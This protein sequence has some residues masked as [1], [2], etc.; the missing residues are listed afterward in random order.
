MEQKI[1]CRGT[2]ILAGLTALFLLFFSVC[3][4]PRVIKPLK[5][6]REGKT[7][8]T[9][10]VEGVQKSYTDGFVKKNDFINLNGLFARLTGRRYCNT[11]VRLNNG[12]LAGGF[13]K[14]D[15]TVGAEKLTAFDRFLEELG[16]PYLYVQPPHKMDLGEELLPEGIDDYGI[17]TG[18][19]R[20]RLLSEAGVDTLDLREELAGTPERVEASFF[21]ADHHWNY[22]AAFTAFQRIT[23]RLKLFFPE[24]AF[25]EACTDLSQWEAHT[26]KDWF[27]GSKGKRTGVFY[28][29]VDDLTYY[30]PRFSTEMSCAVPKHCRFT[31]GSFEDAVI[32]KLYLDAPNYFA[33][34][35]YCIYIGGDYPLT[36]FRN[37]GAPNDL[38]VLLL[39][40]SFGIPVIGYLSTAVRELDVIDPRHFTEC[41]IVEY[42]LRTAPDVVI[43][44]AN[45]SQIPVAAFYDMGVEEA[46]QGEL[47]EKQV[48]AQIP[49]MEHPPKE[50]NKWN[51]Q[52]VATGLKYDTTYLLEFDD[53]TI[54]HGDTKAVN[55]SLLDGEKRLYSGIFDVEYCRE[56]GGFRW[57]VKTPESGEDALWICL[58]SGLAGQTQGIGT[59][60]TG[61]RLTELG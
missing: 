8:F 60:Y 50:N 39:K 5:D 1:R 46:M 43:T 10:F 44:M 54:T 37:S 11:I 27:L 55:V 40:D 28:G 49:T 45:P 41:S 35:P 21:K 47:E 29:G 15:M 59:T 12:M 13:E 17:E 18:D 7:D 31:S 34:N 61:I 22:T 2:A 23:E 57:Y 19:Q 36:Q 20:L 52:E 9:G 14:A 24:A 38:K 16:I 3:N 42:V 32:Q 56:N 33:E 30:T 6:W 48:V 26:L 58:Y 51:F 53:V 25:D 4:I